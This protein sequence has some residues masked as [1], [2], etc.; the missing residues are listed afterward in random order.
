EM[1]KLFDVPKEKTAPHNCSLFIKEN[2]IVL[3][4]YT[5]E[6]EKDKDA[7]GT[8]SKLSVWLAG[9]IFPANK[10]YDYWRDKVGK[11]IVVLQDDEFRDFVMLSTEVITRTKINNETGT[12]QSGALFTE[13]YLPAETVL[14]SLALATPVF[15]K[16]GKDKGIFSQ[17][18]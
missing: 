2:K 5:F 12:V 17:N 8:C 10:D 9:K 15:S 6:I 14:Y 3:E 11:D 18:N 7:S 16:Q 4:E 13:E 1:T